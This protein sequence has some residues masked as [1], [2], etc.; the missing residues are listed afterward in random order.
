[1]CSRDVQKIQQWYHNKYNSRHVT[2]ERA[3]AEALMDLIMKTERKP[4][5]RLSDTQAYSKLYW[6]SRIKAHFEDMWNLES[7]LF[8]DDKDAKAA[9]RMALQHK[10]VKNLYNEEDDETKKKN[11]IQYWPVPRRI[12]NEFSSCW[13]ARG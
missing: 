7:Q 3:Q 11:G 10:V 6:Q 4:P 5:R 13:I 12:D 8:A 2:K 9:A 1:M